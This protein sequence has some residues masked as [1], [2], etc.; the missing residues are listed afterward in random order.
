MNNASLHALAT[1]AATPRRAMVLAAGLGLRMRPITLRLP[2]PLITIAGQTLLDRI[3]DR[4]VEA[5]VSDAVV[6]THHLGPMIAA[7]L[8]GRRSPHIHISPEA[9]LLETGGG[10][11]RALPLLGTEPFYAINGDVL[12]REGAPP[13]LH[14]LA[15]AWDE[16]TMDGLLLLQPIETA[17]GYQG[18]GDFFRRP[19]GRLVRRDERPRAPFIFAGLQIL[20][21]RLF[22]AAPDDAF[23]TNVLFD[24]AIA[25]GRLH[26]VI[27]GGGWCHVGT[28]DDIAP[29]EAFLRTADVAAAAPAAAPAV[30]HA[31]R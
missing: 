23:S 11:T 15:Q 9:T 20:H 31:G 28:P 27:H 21:P 29:A 4:L 3:L 12:W 14:A 8:A 7:H 16:E 17:L 24:A 22:A 6:N 18:A 10:I 25:A 26:G 2:K 30:L 1:P 5:G 13:A 19:D